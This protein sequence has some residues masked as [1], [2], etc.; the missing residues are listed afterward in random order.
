MFSDL[1][2]RETVSAQAAHVR[3]G[4]PGAVLK[5][6]IQGVAGHYAS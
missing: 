3:S 6:I 2:P 4:V 5:G 1:N